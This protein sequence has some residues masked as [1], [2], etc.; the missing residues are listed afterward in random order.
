MKSGGNQILKLISI[1]IQKKIIQNQ[2]QEVIDKL[3]TDLEKHFKN[4]TNEKLLDY[5][6]PVANDANVDVILESL[7]TQK[8]PKTVTEGT[9]RTAFLV[10]EAN[11]LSY[12]PALTN[13]CELVIIND[14]DPAV[15]ESVI[16]LI[17]TLQRVVVQKM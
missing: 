9:I 6:Y 3:I 11:I 13:C 4:E 5:H 17:Q 12:L 16:F 2:E 10:G 1:P 14:V 15:T 8:K 7:E